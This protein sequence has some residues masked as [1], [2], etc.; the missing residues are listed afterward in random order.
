MLFHYLKVSFRQLMKNKVQY[1]LSILGIAIGLL[2]FSVFNYY[3]RETFDQYKAWPNYKNMAHF[4]I[5]SGKDQV[6]WALD[7][8]TLQQLIERPVAGIEKIAYLKRT[9]LPLSFFKDGR[10]VTVSQSV[11]AINTDFIET[12]SLQTID[13][14][15]PE[16]L[17]D[18][19]LISQTY[20]RNLF[21][22]ENPVGKEIRLS[23]DE[24]SSSTYTVSGV[25]R[26]FSPQLQKA[27]ETND[28]YI[29]YEAAI[30][31]N[32]AGSHLFSP[33]ILC[34]KN[35]S[36]KEINQRLKGRFPSYSEKEQEIIV[37]SISEP[38][39]PSERLVRFTI[40][41]L[42]S[43]ILISAM[44]NFLKFT[45]Q[46]FVSRTRELS[47][48][49]SFGSN[50]IRL[51]AMLFTEVLIVLVLSMIASY[52]VTKLFI[53]FYYNYLPPT[54]VQRGLIQ[55][56]EWSLFSQQVEQMFYLLVISSIVCLLALIRI[57]WTNI[58][59]GIRSTG[60]GKH[61]LRNFFLCFQL[62]ICFFFSGFSVVVADLY[63]DHEKLRNKTLSDEECERIWHVQSMTN[64]QW[65]EQATE[66]I[67]DIRSL[68]SVEDVLLYRRLSTKTVLTDSGEFV[69]RTSFVGGNYGRFMNLPVSGRMPGN[70]NEVAVS[71]SL[72]QAL[73]TAGSAENFRIGDEYYRITGTYESLPF[74]LLESPPYSEKSFSII[75]YIPE[76][77]LAGFYIKAIAGQEKK[78]REAILE[79]IRKYIP[80]F[81]KQLLVGMHDENRMSS[82]G[83]AK[84]AS[85]LLLLLSIVSLLI[86]SLGI[87]S[88][89]T[90]DTR[91]RRKEVAIRKI[92][93]AGKKEIALLFGKL[94]I[95]LLIISAVII[96]PVDYL[97]GWKSGTP[98]SFFHL[99]I[100]VLIVSSIVFITVFWR[101][102]QILKVNPAEVI[103]SE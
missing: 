3:L 100:T 85:D 24:N 57:K 82:F 80:G 13:K 61:K 76:N 23:W 7:E 65:F 48:R 36:L 60:Q 1:T 25:L 19:V 43:L 97:I 12:F 33:T 64:E 66:I 74:D 34:A 47:L 77:E 56:N 83:S 38:G 6:R 59:V 89:I 63:L 37:K 73:E 22:D 31:E 29:L 46:S 53:W 28:V 20:A 10:E 99:L 8:P 98:F 95:N 27:Y 90:L 5:D 92:N 4:Y 58:V 67:S 101:I 44:I 75:I 86:T 102:W 103:K 84:T 52:F 42:A 71:R 88:A 51:F 16:L 41:L 50:N 9:S 62:I 21:G 39:N 2:C 68:N 96:L 18:R 17:S 72:K 40:L 32:F 93:G 30:H 11:Y 70:A 91:S 14:K 55:I 54:V 94:Y 49:K 69:A 45:I 26:D 78:A 79:T 81:E 15:T 87:Y 35:V